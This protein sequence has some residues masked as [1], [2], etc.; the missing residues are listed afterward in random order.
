MGPG[1]SWLDLKLK[2]R[3]V[4]VDEPIDLNSKILRMSNK[5]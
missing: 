4:D 3:V 2:L 1:L 5:K